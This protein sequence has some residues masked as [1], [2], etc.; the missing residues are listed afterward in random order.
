MGL[1]EV[2]PLLGVLQQFAVFPGLSIG[3]F[4]MHGLASLQVSLIGAGLCS[5]QVPL[6]RADQALGLYLETGPVRGG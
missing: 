4:V 6:L 2:S 1:P 3:D 5:P